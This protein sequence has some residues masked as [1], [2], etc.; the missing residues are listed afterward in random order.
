[1]KLVLSLYFFMIAIVQFGILFGIYHYYQSQET[2]APSRYWFK[3][4]SLNAIALVLF[5]AGILIIKDISQPPFSFTIA[6]TLFYASSVMQTLFCISLRKKIPKHI[7]IIFFSTIFIFVLFFEYLRQT[8][9][10]ET[11]TIIMVLFV[12]FFMFFK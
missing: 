5:G 10:F 7:E 11:R 9:D 1:M 8:S 12:C 6:N 3:S 2:I 4:L